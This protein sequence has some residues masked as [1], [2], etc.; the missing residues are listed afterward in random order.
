MER[1][2]IFAWFMLGALIIS[3]VASVVVNFKIS[4][5]KNATIEKKQAEIDLLE[6]QQ[7]SFMRANYEALQKSAEETIST[8]QITLVEAEETIKELQQAMADLKTQ[9]DKATAEKSVYQHQY[10]QVAQ[11]VAQVHVLLAKFRGDVDHLD[12][13][14]IE[15]KGHAMSSATARGTL[16]TGGSGDV[17]PTTPSSSSPPPQRKP[18]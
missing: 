9:L 13:R 18:T 8:L 10:Q 12:Q 15:L 6:R 5:T 7:P 3:G 17:K 14:V 16:T 11:R 1:E 2:E 4:K